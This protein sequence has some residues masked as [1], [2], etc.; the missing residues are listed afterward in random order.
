MYRTRIV[1]RFVLVACLASLVVST[2]AS[3]ADAQRFGSFYTYRNPRTGRTYTYGSS[4][5]YG[6]FNRFY[7]YGSGN[8]YQSSYFGFGGSPGHRRYWGGSFYG[9]S[10]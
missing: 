4:Y 9:N 7:G 5:G 10:H 2:V 6:G 3:S 8:R 1:R